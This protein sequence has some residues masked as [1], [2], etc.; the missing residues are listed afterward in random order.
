MGN[1]ITAIEEFDFKPGRIISKKYEVLSKLGGGWEAEVYLVRELGTNIERAAKFFFPHRNSGGKVLNRY[2]RKLHKLR[3][4]PALIRY[5]TK[6]TIQFK[7]EEVTYLVSD[8]VEGELLS[9]FLKRQPGKRIPDFQAVHLLHALTLGL[10]P[11]H[12]L[13]DYHGD[14]HSEN[15]IIRRHGLGFDLK[16]LDLYHWGR[17]TNKDFQDEIVDVIKIFYDSLGGKRYYAKQR[18]AIKEICCGLKRSLIL[19]KFRTITKL[20]EHLETMSW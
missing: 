14:L 15:V 17:A 1:S 7:K 6:E 5:H 4:C 10:E 19:K 12:R 16:F 20:R 11:I 8:Y 2:A 18:P 3:G 9:D 13:K